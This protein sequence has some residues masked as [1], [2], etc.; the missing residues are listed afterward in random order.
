MIYTWFLL[1][2]LIEIFI[3]FRTIFELARKPS[4]RNFDWT[5]WMVGCVRHIRRKHEELFIE[6]N[7]VY[8]NVIDV[9][10]FFPTNEWHT[11][12]MGEIKLFL[13]ISF[14]PLRV[15]CQSHLREFNWWDLLYCFATVSFSLY[16]SSEFMSFQFLWCLLLLLH[17]LLSL[18]TT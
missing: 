6:W 15:R 8:G 13:L 7:V 9:F 11:L 1:C 5:L 10:I 16:P 14:M 4:D 17:S 2:I 12:R 18:L 3:A